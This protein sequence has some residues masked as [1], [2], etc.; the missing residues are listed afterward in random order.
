MKNII[1][2]VLIALVTLPF[3]SDAQHHN[4]STG[5]QIST[6]YD[7]WYDRNY[8]Q[9]D[10]FSLGPSMYVTRKIYK[11]L[12]AEVSF[13]YL[14]QNEKNI[15]ESTVGGIETRQKAI[16]S[17]LGLNCNI[18]DQPKVQLFLGFGIT[19]RYYSLKEEEKYYLNG[20]VTYYDSYK[21][22]Q[23][24]FAYTLYLGAGIKY[25]IYRCL[26]LNLNTRVESLT[27][28]LVYSREVSKK[29]DFYITPT[30]QI[31]IGLKF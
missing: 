1:V 5:I 26:F 18:V 23:N 27:E 13:N 8:W 2:I 17:S 3:N 24:W 9:R 20:V 25:H 28:E 10:K 7:S 31:G 30:I 19:N 6:R 14:F 21:Y 29:A 12:S 4:W 22:T 15:I 16:Y 11:R